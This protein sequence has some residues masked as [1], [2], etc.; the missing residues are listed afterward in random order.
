MAGTLRI[1]RLEAELELLRS[2][3]YQIVNGKPSRLKDSR[4]LPLSQKLDLLIIEIQREKKKM[5]KI[6]TTH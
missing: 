3:L 2:E 1:K 5:A 6:K 4:V